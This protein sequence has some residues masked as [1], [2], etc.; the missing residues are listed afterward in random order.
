[1]SQLPAGAKEICRKFDL[2]GDGYITKKELRE[3]FSKSEM[4]DK[5]INDLLK[6]ADENRD[7]KVNYEG[8]I[9][10]LLVTGDS[11]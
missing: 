8:M 5:E 2:N 1:M 11:R 3:A 6:T 10:R 4:S 7:G 9:A